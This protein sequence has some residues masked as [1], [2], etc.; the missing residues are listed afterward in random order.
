MNIFSKIEPYKLD[1]LAVD[2]DH[3]LY[4]EQSWNP[5][6]IPVLFLHGGPGAGTSSIYRRF[7]DPTKYR[8]ILFDQR[9][10][11]KSSPYGSINNNTSQ[12]LIEDIKNILDFLDIKKTIIY[13][14]SWGS[15]L[16][17]LFS[18][19][20]PSYVYSM[21]LRGVFLCRKSDIMWFYQR[22]AHEV[23]P[24][25]W[26]DF[27]SLIP[28]EE[29]SDILS[30]YHKR[31][32]GDDLDLSKELC[33]RWAIWEGRCSTLYPSDDVVNQFDECAISLSKIETHFFQNDC[34]IEENQIINNIEVLKDIKCEIIHGRYDI[35]CPF[36]QAYDL[37]KVYINSRLHII[38]DAGHSILEP[39]ITK[40]LLEIFNNHDELIS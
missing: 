37:H 3:K 17:L 18:Q 7:F 22:G 2:N 9:G 27:I 23:F 19:K 34:F 16:A 21:V 13:G 29:R 11:G 20:Y 15:T 1:Y 35:V 40:K 31:I 4:I 14:G 36:Q 33:Q 30:A 38:E 6:G 24:D 28:T 25:Y 39:G 32:H 10:S 5:S 8:I 12:K 26:S